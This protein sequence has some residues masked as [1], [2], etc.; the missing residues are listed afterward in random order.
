MGNIGSIDSYIY[1][2]SE[3]YTDN[4]ISQ[5]QKNQEIYIWDMTWVKD[6]CDEDLTENIKSYTKIC[7]NTIQKMI[8]STQE[9]HPDIHIKN[10]K[11]GKKVIENLIQGESFLQKLVMEGINLDQELVR[12][13]FTTGVRLTKKNI[14]ELKELKSRESRNKYLI[15]RLQNGVANPRKKPEDQT[16]NEYITSVLLALYRANTDELKRINWSR[17]VIL[18]ETISKFANI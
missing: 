4:L 16:I 2:E 9:N 12:S 11:L 15:K 7:H 13:V 3:K 18:C 14:A 17:A 10:E 8:E 5:S 6:E 1:S